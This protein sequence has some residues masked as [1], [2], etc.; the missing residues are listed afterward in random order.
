M[1]HRGRT[2][3]GR[4]GA[5]TSTLITDRVTLVYPREDRRR[6]RIQRLLADDP[7]PKRP[8]TLPSL[9]FLEGPFDDLDENG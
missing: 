4:L 9:K 1:S 7:K 2:G 8:I 3:K 5:S 6:K